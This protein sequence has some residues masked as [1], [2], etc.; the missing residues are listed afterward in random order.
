MRS[1]STPLSTRWKC[2]WHSSQISRCPWKPIYNPVHNN[3]S[4]AI[5][6][7]LYFGLKGN[8]SNHE[9]FPSPPGAGSKEKQKVNWLWQRTA[10]SW[11]PA[12]HYH[13]E[14]EEDSKSTWFSSP[15]ICLNCIYLKCNIY[16]LGE[17]WKYCEMLLYLPCVCAF[18]QTKTW[19][20]PRG[21]LMIST[22]ACRMSCP[23]S[24]IG[25]IFYG[26]LLMKFVL[27]NG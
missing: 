21:F 17:A 24:G 20:R 14:W 15:L 27:N 5:N 9:C 1:L 25:E 11:D 8:H 4:S 2:I 18:R 23:C 19:K 7:L 26:W 10:P 3:G 13:E 16:W 22:L 6:K 12:D